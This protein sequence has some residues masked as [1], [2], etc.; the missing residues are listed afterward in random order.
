M[1]D[2]DTIRAVAAILRGSF[3]GYFLWDDEEWEKVACE[4]VARVK[5]G[6]IDV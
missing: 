1:S 5:E 4:V 6:A 2:E 3:M